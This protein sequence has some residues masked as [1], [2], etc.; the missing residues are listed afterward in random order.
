M[1]NYHLPTRAASR[2]VALSIILLLLAVVANAYTV[3]M[4]GGRRI[5]I[6]SRFVVTPATL[7]YQVTEGIQITIPMAAINIPATEKA[8]NEA[9]GSLL[10]RAQI[11]KEE[12][13]VSR[14]V[15]ENQKANSGGRR[16][17]TNRDLEM[18]MR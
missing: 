16:T 12:S 11:A 2:I 13:S 3:I 15:I 6:P 9:P 17:I 4:H 14:D 5:E 10:K 1:V 8:N 18:S 7:T